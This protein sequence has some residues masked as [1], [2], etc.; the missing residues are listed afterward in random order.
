MSEKYKDR[1]VLAVGIP[2][3][4]S[5]EIHQGKDEGII[6]VSMIQKTKPYIDGNGYEM[7]LECKQLRIPKHI[8]L[9]TKMPK[10][11]LVLEKVK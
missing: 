4:G 7:E 5:G 1:Y 3:F 9:S 6:G 11:R 8:R 10:Y 2:D